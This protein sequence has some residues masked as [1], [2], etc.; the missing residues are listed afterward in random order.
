MKKIDLKM[1]TNDELLAE[2][3]RVDEEISRCMDNES[4]RDSVDI[5]KPLNR[6][7]LQYLKK[8]DTELEFRGIN[9]NK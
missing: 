3:E 4:I 5:K 1:A 2:R 8:I 7:L 9:L 6:E